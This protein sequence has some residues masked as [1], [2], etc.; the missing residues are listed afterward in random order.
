MEKSS[1]NVL[2]KINWT[3]HKEQREINMFWSDFKIKNEWLIGSRG[4]KRD[5]KSSQKY[6]TSTPG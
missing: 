6:K 1:V 3:H 5:W 2:E 4:L